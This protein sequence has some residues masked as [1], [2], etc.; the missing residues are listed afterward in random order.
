MTEACV[1]KTINVPGVPPP[2]LPPPPP[3]LC[4]NTTGDDAGAEIAFVNSMCTEAVV[5]YFT[6]AS[7]SRETM[8]VNN[9]DKF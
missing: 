2:A 5:M 3:L 1:I 8:A 4:A 6:I 7:G 9:D